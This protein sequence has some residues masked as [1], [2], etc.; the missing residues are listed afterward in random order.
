ML[1]A[2]QCGG[3]LT[4]TAR[5]DVGNVLAL[6]SETIIKMRQV[7]VTHMTRIYLGVLDAADEANQEGINRTKLEQAWPSR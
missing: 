4:Q 1:L 6:C 5:D 7:H 2:A 3:S